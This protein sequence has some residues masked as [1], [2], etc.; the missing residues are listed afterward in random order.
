MGFKQFHVHNREV[1][2]REAQ[3]VLFIIHRNDVRIIHEK[4]NT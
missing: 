3:I 1:F 4:S 2:E